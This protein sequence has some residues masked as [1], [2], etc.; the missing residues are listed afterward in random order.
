MREEGAKGNVTN[1]FLGTLD[2][3]RSWRVS[4]SR[5][6]IEVSKLHGTPNKST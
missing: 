6:N 2:K 5:A 3:W 1:E 4:T